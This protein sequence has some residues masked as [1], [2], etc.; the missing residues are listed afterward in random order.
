M[1]CKLIINKQKSAGVVVNLKVAVMVAIILKIACL[2][3]CS[4]ILDSV[5]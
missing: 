5:C 1:T 3:K 4:V 2:C